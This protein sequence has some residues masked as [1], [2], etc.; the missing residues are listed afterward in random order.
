MSRYE[1]VAAAS[2]AGTSLV[3]NLKHF[4]VTLATWDAVWEVYPDLKWAWQRLRLY[5]AQ[6]RALEHFFKKLEEE[7][8]K[9]S[10]QR[11]GRAKQLV[12]FFC[13]TTTGTRGGWG[14]HAATRQPHP[15]AAL[16]PQG[17]AS[18]AKPAP[19]PGRWVD[20]DCNAALDMQRIG[21]A[22]WRPLELCWW[23]E[24]GA[25]PAKGK[26]YPCLAYKR[27]QDKAPKA[28]QQL[29]PAVAQ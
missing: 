9:L 27:L 23:P 16:A 19:Q 2:S 10:M 26:E 7:M 13:A 3:A 11:H 17:E 12:V 8:A 25:L 20:R 1:L 4:R 21:E 5:R 18:K 6:D 22:K 14:P 24:Q 28:Q 29:Q 15:A